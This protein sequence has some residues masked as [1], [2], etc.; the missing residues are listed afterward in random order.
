MEKRIRDKTNGLNYTLQ[1]DYYFSELI[2][3]E[4]EATYRK[5]G[6]LRKNYLKEHK[7]GYYQYLILT[8]KLTEHLNQI[9]KEAGEQVEI[10]V[11]Q[12][13]EKYGVTEEM[14]EE[15]WMEWVRRMNDI[16][17]KVE[18]IIRGEILYI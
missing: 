6:I 2:I 7:S 18:E 8:G 11:K 10:L 15:N 14:R 12:M 5:Y 1:G 4:E 16:K 13:A 3:K 17:E 9:D